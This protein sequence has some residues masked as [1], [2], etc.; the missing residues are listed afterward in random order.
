MAF[1]EDV[2]PDGRPCTEGG[3]DYCKVFEVCSAM[4]LIMNSV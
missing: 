1:E 2:G 3:E 4:E